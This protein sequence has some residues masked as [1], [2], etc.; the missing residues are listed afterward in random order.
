MVVARKIPVLNPDAQL[1]YEV[2]LD[3]FVSCDNAANKARM[4]VVR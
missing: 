2:T 1:L 3:L 4:I